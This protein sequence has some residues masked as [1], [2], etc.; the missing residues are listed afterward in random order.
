MDKNIKIAIVKKEKEDYNSAVSYYTP[1]L[2]VTYCL[3]FILGKVVVAMI[4]LLIGIPAVLAA[5]F[6]VVRN[7][8][9]RDII[10]YT[11]AGAVMLMTLFLSHS[12]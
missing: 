12:G 1:F 8:R 4:P 9:I 2:S 5:V 11:G 10:V 7:E 6:Q 3:S